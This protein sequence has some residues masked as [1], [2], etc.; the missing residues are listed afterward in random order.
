MDELVVVITTVGHEADAGRI[1]RA[2][3]E[4]RLAACVNIVP[5]VRSIYAWEQQIHDQQELLLLI[6]TSAAREPEL[7]AALLE[8]HPYETPEYVVFASGDVEARYA[9]WIRNSTTR[10]E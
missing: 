9:E 8:M 10:G 7:R 3:V 4:N 5:G 6:K 1:A 2:L